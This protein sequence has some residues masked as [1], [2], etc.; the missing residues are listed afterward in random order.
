MLHALLVLLALAQFPQPPGQQQAAAPTPGT[1]TIR[2][3]VFAA[4]SGQPLRKAQVRI[5]ANEIRENRMTTTDV[6]GGYEFTEVRAGRY[7]V[8]ASKGS[9]VQMSYGQQ[10]PTDVGRPIEVLDRQ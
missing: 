6:N 9:F 10:R 4:D 2:G 8:T 1:A 7:T 5:V 3:H